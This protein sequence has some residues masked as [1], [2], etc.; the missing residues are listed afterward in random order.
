MLKLNS[1]GALAAVLVAAAL[2]TLGATTVASLPPAKTFGVSITGLPQ[3]TNQL[4]SFDRMVGRR[5][6]F[7]DWYDDFTT[8]DPASFVASVASVGAENMIAW[9]G[10]D[11]NALPNGVTDPTTALATIIDGRW[12]GLLTTWATAL[13][14]FGKPVL[15]RFLP[16]MNGDWNPTSEG[17]NGNAPGQFAQAWIHAHDIFTAMGATNVK[18]VWDVN[19]DYSGSTPLKELYPGDAYVD[20]VGIDGY[21]WGTSQSWSTWQSPQQVFDGTL[22]DIATFTKMRVIICETASSE[23]GGNKANWIRSFFSFVESTPAIVGFSWFEFNKET[24]WQVNSS[25][26]ALAAFQVGLG[27]LFHP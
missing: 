15:L 20:Y 23:L 27:R 16:E 7:A 8:P 24:N 6:N 21:N 10:Y 11:A 9:E 2:P 18:W 25:P 12:D 14:A 19:V 13:K 3:S 5:V 4:H 17:V 26:A 22:A 1:I